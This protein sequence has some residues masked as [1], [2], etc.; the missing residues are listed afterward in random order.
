MGGRTDGVSE[1]WSNAKRANS[2]LRLHTFV[3]HYSDAPVLPS[4]HTSRKGAPLITPLSLARACRRFASD[5]KASK[6]TILDLR[7]LSSMTDYFV[8]C[9][10]ASEPHL[11]AVVNEIETKLKEKGVHPSHV[12]GRPASNW[13]VMDYVDVVVHVMRDNIRDFYGLERLWG[14]AKKVK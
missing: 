8:I 7:G 9:S 3:T 2:L 1:R 11:K 5:K 4:F 10:A 12:D 13:M 14:D 6:I